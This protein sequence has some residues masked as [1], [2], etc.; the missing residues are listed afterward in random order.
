MTKN[1][2]LLSL[3]LLLLL[4]NL[5]YAQETI[6]LD[7]QIT[8]KKTGKI[9]TGLKEKDFELYEDG[10]KQQISQL[11]QEKLP[12]SLLI[13]FN[14]DKPVL[15]ILDQIK[16]AVETS[17]Q[18]LKP[19][20]E[21]SVIAFSGGSPAIVK[22]TTDKQLIAKQIPDILSQSTQLGESNSLVKTLLD[23]TK[24]I[25]AVA[26]PQ[27]RKVI[28]SI[29]DNF[30]GALVS[31]EL[32]KKAD[33]TIASSTT[34]ING[35]ILQGLIFTNSGSL[36][37]VTGP[38]TDPALNNRPSTSTREVQSTRGTTQITTTQATRDSSLRDLTDGETRFSVTPSESV[39]IQSQKT[40]GEFY[41]VQKDQLKDRLSDLIDNI[42][43]S[44]TISY[45][46]AN[47]KQ[48]GKYR[49]IKIKISKEVEKQQGDVVIKAKK[50]YLV[51]KK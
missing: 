18:K 25:Q 7:I 51:P 10:K 38:G 5:I 40:G 47:N 19:E 41:N 27:N 22:F 31:S 30:G 24:Y 48:D 43:K 16:D 11:S 9:V 36:G 14:V 33:Q 45:T 13:I 21:V 28:I 12:V 34:V 26:K 2:F 39:K 42:S 37:S 17:L 32:E 29:T 6:S 3:L 1:R 35:V 49:Q 20:D 44:Y 4:S 50:E 15:P 8:N 46:S 23:S